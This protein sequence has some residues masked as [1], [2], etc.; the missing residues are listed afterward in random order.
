MPDIIVFDGV[1]N[2][3]A[4][5]VRFILRHGTMPH[6]QF[7]PLQSRVG[8]G[9]LNTHGFSPEDGADARTAIAFPGRVGSAERLK[10]GSR[11]ATVTAC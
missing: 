3:C 6:F 5:S 10:I 2:L 9:L 7:A 11:R 4:H 8:T 1:C